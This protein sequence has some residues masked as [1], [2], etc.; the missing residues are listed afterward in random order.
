MLLHDHR[1]F[2]FKVSR[3]GWLLSSETRRRLLW[4]IRSSVSEKPVTTQFR[5]ESST[6]TIVRIYQTARSHV[7]QD[8]KVIYTKSVTVRNWWEIMS[9]GT[10]SHYYVFLATDVTLFSGNYMQGCVPW[11][12]VLLHSRWACFRFLWISQICCLG[13]WARTGVSLKGALPARWVFF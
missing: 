7:P 9:C 13:H 2:V 5:T 4:Q 10:N 11:T 1:F 6:K 3:C 12:D 8:H